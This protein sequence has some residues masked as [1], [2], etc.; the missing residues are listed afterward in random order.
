MYSCI[1]TPYRVLIAVL[2]GFYMRSAVFIIWYSVV[3][4]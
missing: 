4:K 1:M 2:L 3:R